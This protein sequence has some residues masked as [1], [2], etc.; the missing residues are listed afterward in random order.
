MATTSSTTDRTTARHELVGNR[1]VLA[2][3]VLYLLEWVAIIGGQ[4]WEPPYALSDSPDQ[5]LDGYLGQGHS[6]GWVATWFSVV[7]LGRVLIIIGLRKSLSDSGRHHTLMDFAIVAMAASVIIEVVTYGLIASAGAHADNGGSAETVHVLNQV[8]VT[9]EDLVVGPYGLAVALACWCM[10]RSG[11][12]PRVLCGL[13]A[14]GSAAIL[15][16]TMALGGP[17][18]PGVEDP[19]AG[20]GTL[21]TWIWMI[22]AGVLLWRRAAPVRRRRTDG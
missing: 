22:W 17:A 14:V 9:L 20:N 21:L 2:G 5:V 1:L 6:L 4:A 18:Y 15:L 13:G 8:G 3:T 7:L 19:L 16:D 12:F 10:W 11:L